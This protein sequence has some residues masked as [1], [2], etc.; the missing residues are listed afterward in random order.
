MMV[1]EILAR[2]HVSGIEDDHPMNPSLILRNMSE[3]F[4]RTF[5]YCLEYNALT[6]MGLC[7]YQD[8]FVTRSVYLLG[9]GYLNAVAINSIGMVGA[10]I[11][12]Q[13]FRKMT[14]LRKNSLDNT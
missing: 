13:T 12:M 6:N 5:Q 11:A 9:R 8:F 14:K 1:T 7:L 2:Q 4:L 3:S 10:L